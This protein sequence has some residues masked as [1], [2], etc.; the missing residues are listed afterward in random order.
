MTIDEPGRIPRYLI[1]VTAFGILGALVILVRFIHLNGF[2]VDELYTFHAIRLP[3]HEML[4]ERLRRGHFIGYFALLKL[5]YKPL[6]AY[7]AETVLRSFSI[8]TWLAAAISYGALARRFLPLRAFALATLLLALNGV[9]IRQAGEGRMYTLVLL[10]SVWITRCYFELESGAAPRKWSFALILSTIF[11]FAVSASTGLLSVAL[12]YDAFRSRKSKPILLKAAIPAL[13]CGTLVFLP[14]AIVHLHTRER[15]GIVGS[16][17]YNI[18]AHPITMFTGVQVRDNY[19]DPTSLLRALVMLGALIT[20]YVLVRL[21]RIRKEFTHLELTSARVVFLPLLIIAFTEMLSSYTDFTLL[22]PPRYLTCLLPCAALLSAT[23]LDPLLRSKM[24]V[25]VNLT[26][27]ALLLTNA[28]AITTVTTDGTFFRERLRW[29][30]E[31]WYRPGD[32]VIVVPYEAADGVELYAPGVR[33]DVAIDRYN[34]DVKSLATQIA[35]LHSR[36]RVLL[37]CYRPLNSPIVQVAEALFGPAT[38][39]RPEK[40]NG[41]M[42]IFKFNPE[43]AGI[44]DQ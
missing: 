23:A 37:V 16:K 29:M 27:A 18:I 25:P 28:Y 30:H 35:Q 36:P 8:V 22:G 21:W 10:V 5:I 33:V 44:E 12:L 39:N 24:A 2:W 4:W 32:G 38:S 19:F 1:A 17:A 9:S 34:L 26:A 13:L 14:G 7:N 20:A 43:L 15:L 42:R 6:Q 3:W 11:G 41:T 31:E 40:P